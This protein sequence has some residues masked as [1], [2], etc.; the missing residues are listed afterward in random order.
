[1]LHPISSASSLH[2]ILALQ[3]HPQSS[4]STARQRHTHPEFLSRLP[5]KCKEVL[6]STE[7]DPKV[8]SYDKRS[9][10]VKAGLYFSAGIPSKGIPPPAFQITTDKAVTKMQN[11]FRKYLIISFQTSTSEQKPS[12]FEIN[13]S[14]Q[15]EVGDIQC[16]LLL[17]SC[18]NWK[19][20]TNF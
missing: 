17:N 4:V 7:H 1:M 10:R 11:W 20:E 8:Q 18:L 6:Q 5:G 19:K 16:V 12:C 9:P 15:G 2:T 14:G 3:K 13:G